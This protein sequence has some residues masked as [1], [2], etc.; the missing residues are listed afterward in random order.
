[1]DGGTGFCAAL[2]IKENLAQLFNS[3]LGWDLFGL[4]TSCVEMGQNS[5]PKHHCSH[6]RSVSKMSVLPEQGKNR[7]N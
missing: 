2:E 1:M 5:T 4:V 3:L 7:Q 6:V